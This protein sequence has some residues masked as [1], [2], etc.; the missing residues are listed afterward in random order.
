MKRW[1][2]SVG[3]VFFTLWGFAAE[4]GKTYELWYCRPAFNRGADYDRVMSRGF[5]YDEDW[6]RWSLPIG[7]GYMGAAIFGRTD[8]ER[9]QLSEKTLANRGCYD[10]GGFTNE[11]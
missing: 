6:E 1:L 4:V 7:N 2:L 3:V 11:L 10:Q 9:I 5:P 8:T